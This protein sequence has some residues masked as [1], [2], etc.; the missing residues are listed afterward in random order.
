MGSRLG[1]LMV[2]SSTICR[3][4]LGTIN[5]CCAVCGRVVFM[6]PQKYNSKLRRIVSGG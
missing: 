2:P 1:N 6:I 5:G 3:H 4:N